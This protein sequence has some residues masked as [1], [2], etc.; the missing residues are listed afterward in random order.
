MEIHKRIALARKKKGLTQE[1]L[2]E[3]TNITSRTIQRIESGESTP[4]AFTIKAI[5]AALDTTFEELT[6]EPQNDS[7]GLP[8]TENAFDVESEKH[9]L[10]MLCLSCFAYLVIPFVHFLLPIYLLKKH[11]GAIVNSRAFGRSV[12]RQQIYWVVALNLSLILLFVY[13]FIVAT[14]FK[15]L[16]LVNYLWV[17]CIMYVLNAALI[18]INLFR[19]KS[20]DFVTASPL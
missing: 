19:V 12:I 14:H 2:A 1:Q 5:A 11:V 20:L 6:S 17:F 8:A 16:Y 18:T 7:V 4:R 15:E 3:L 10:T 13:N 9:F